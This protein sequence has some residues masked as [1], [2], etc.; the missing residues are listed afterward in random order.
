M[1]RQKQALPQLDQDF[2]VAWQNKQ[3][4]YS[5][6]LPYTLQKA[7][8]HFFNIM[9]ISPNNHPLL[10]CYVCK[11]V[12]LL[13]AVPYNIMLSWGPTFDRTESVINDYWKTCNPNPTLNA[14]CSIKL[15]AWNYLSYNGFLQINK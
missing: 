5:S 14:S 3:L 6:S 11:T 10:N 1:A 9:H 2:I 15:L 12:H 8:A 4:P 7:T 13:G